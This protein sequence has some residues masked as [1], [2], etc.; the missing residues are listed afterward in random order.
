[1]KLDTTLNNLADAFPRDFSEDEKASAKTIFL[2][3]LS[4]LAP[5]FV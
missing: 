4:L 2:K 3:K 5:A 1:M